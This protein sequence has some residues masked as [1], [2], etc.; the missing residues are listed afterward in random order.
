MRLGPIVCLGMLVTYDWVQEGYPWWYFA[1]AVLVGIAWNYA[2]AALG[3]L[4]PPV[5]K[6]QGPFLP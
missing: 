1:L 3:E 6:K 5:E 4:V 2:A